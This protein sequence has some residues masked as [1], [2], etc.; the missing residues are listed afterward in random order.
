MYVVM[1]CN[2]VRYFCTKQCIWPSVVSSLF[3]VKA[4]DC[5][6]ILAVRA[7]EKHVPIIS[8]GS[9]ES[10]RV[11]ADW[12]LVY[13]W[14]Y[15]DNQRHFKRA[16]ICLDNLYI[17]NLWPFECRLPYRCLTHSPCLH[18]LFRLPPLPLR[19]PAF[20]LHFACSSLLL[21]FFCHLAVLPPT[22]FSPF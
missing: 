13:S 15:L 4:E 10:E 22:R 14:R 7:K 2:F 6:R 8:S 18:P 5:S 20:A 17:L 1:L 19:A 11:R 21:P 12:W 16:S 3:L 9:A